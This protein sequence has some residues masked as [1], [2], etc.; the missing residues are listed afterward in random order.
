MLDGQIQPVACKDG[1]M[2]LTGEVPSRGRLEICKGHVWGTVCHSYGFS[3]GEAKV[4][5]RA[6]GYGS[7]FTS[8]EI[9]LCVLNIIKFS[10][11]PSS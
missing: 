5:C 9:S 11:C 10:H 3:G 4:A 1:E 8:G 2:R 7:D 6:L